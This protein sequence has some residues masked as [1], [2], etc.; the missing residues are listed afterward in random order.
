MLNC[1]KNDSVRGSIPALGMG[2]P[3]LAGFYSYSL[4]CAPSVIP[5]LLRPVKHSSTVSSP[6]ALITAMPSFVAFLELCW[7]VYRL[8]SMQLPDLL[9]DA[10]RRQ[11]I[12]PI[13]RD[14]HWLPVKERILYKIGILTFQCVKKTGPAYLVE[15]FARV[16]DVYGHSTLLRS[17]WLYHT[18]DKNCN[19]CPRSFAPSIHPSNMF[20]NPSLN[21]GVLDQTLFSQTPTFWLHH[22]LFQD[23]VVGLIEIYQWKYPWWQA[24]RIFWESSVMNASYWNIQYSELFAPEA[25]ILVQNAPKSLAAGAPPQ[26]PLGE[27]TAL[28][29][30]P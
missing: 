21:R 8:F 3:G 1:T 15:M 14:L 9:V 17:A 24:G 13:L 27:L 19:F 2:A 20:D 25:S 29:Q 5:S 4:R 18:S 11:H 6:A 10:G 7:D 28:P 30:T 12:T 26:T 22:I 23:Y 16:S